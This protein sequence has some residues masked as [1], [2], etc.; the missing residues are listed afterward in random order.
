MN[1]S[2]AARRCCSL[3]VVSLLSANGLGAQA[4]PAKLAAPREQIEKIC[5]TE[6]AAKGFDSSF[7][8]SRVEVSATGVNQGMS[9]QLQKASKR[10]EFNCV[11]DFQLKVIDVAVS[12]LADAAAVP[13]R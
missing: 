6:L 8:F 1:A 2:I 12:P 7:M 5:R 9:G 10:W 11:L 13:Q 4:G 3:A